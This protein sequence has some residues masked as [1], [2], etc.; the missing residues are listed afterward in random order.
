[1]ACMIYSGA[2]SSRIIEEM[3]LN[4]KFQTDNLPTHTTVDS[5]LYRTLSVSYRQ[6]T[7]G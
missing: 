3:E 1:M 6:T 7:D 4:T 2:K 5:S